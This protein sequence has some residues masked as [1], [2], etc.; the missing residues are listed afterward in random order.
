V[1]LISNRIGATFLQRNEIQ[2][3]PKWF[4]YARSIFAIA[5]APLTSHNAPDFARRANLPRAA[6]SDFRNYRGQY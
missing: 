5:A 4:C 1:H 2:A 3:H 6:T